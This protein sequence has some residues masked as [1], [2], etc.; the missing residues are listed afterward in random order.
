MIAYLDGKLA[1]KDPTRVVLDV[2]GVGYE[3][4]VPLTCYG[5]LPDAGARCR[6]LVHENIRED[7]Y[8]LYGFVD[9]AD[10]RMFRLLLGV[11]G[12]GP[13]LALAVLSGLAPRDLTRAV[14]EGDVRRLS[15]IPGIGKKTAERLVVELKHKL[16]EGDILAASAAAA[17]GGAPAH[18]RDAV[19][20]LISLGFK[21]AE[22]QAL[23]QKAAAAD[24]SAAVEELVRKALAG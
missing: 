3:L 22:A 16:D 15:S 19:L 6:L 4:S 20:A 5:R 23:V 14:V 17:P 12:V 9:E 2:N 21:Q 18:L 1:E 8:A 7:A 24:P 10:R 13:K 11:S